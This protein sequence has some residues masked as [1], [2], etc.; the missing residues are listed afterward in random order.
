MRAASPMNVLRRAVWPTATRPAVTT[1]AVVALRRIASPSNA[2][3]K[4]GTIHAASALEPAATTSRQSVPAAIDGAPERA[5]SSTPSSV[6]AT[7]AEAAGRHRGPLLHVTARATQATDATSN[8]APVSQAA[9]PS[10][11]SAV[12]R[13]RQRPWSATGESVRSASAAYASRS[14]GRSSDVGDR[15]S[16]SHLTVIVR[17]RSAN[18]WT[19][20]GRRPAVG[21]AACSVCSYL[22]PNRA[23]G[24]A[25]GVRG[26]GHRA[27]DHGG[28]TRR[29]TWDRRRASVR[30]GSRYAG[31]RLTRW[32]RSVV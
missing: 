1:R 7:A 2:C 4:R 22:L 16:T 27:S 30:R 29:R 28:H 20:G 10:V 19:A 15:S 32:L 31:R 12:A 21:I 5:P 9:S 18:P 23:H 26:R 24:R 6:A 17:R 25:R 11:P 13:G 3:G 14:M 8:A